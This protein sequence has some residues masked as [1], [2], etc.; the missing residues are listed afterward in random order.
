M[1]LIEDIQREATDHVSEALEEAR[2]LLN[3]IMTPSLSSS[4]SASLTTPGDES[5]GQSP[6]APPDVR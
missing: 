1:K 4:N 2:E 3:E 5:S 6:T